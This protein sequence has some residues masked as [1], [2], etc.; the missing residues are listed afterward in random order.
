VDLVRNIHAILE[1]IYVELGLAKYRELWVEH[2]FPLRANTKELIAAFKK[3]PSGF[4]EVE[5]G[6]EMDRKREKKKMEQTTN[7]TKWP[8]ASR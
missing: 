6:Q 2:D 7:N 3:W 4:L 8:A 1:R 5:T